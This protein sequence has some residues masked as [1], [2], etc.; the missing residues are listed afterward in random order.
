MVAPS[1]HSLQWEWLRLLAQVST[2][3]LGWLGSRQTHRLDSVRFHDLRHCQAS[4]LLA[5]GYNIK[6]ISELLGHRNASTTLNIYSH[7]MPNIQA[8]AAE[9]LERQLTRR[10]EASP[11][12]VS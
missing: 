7:L 1:R 2:S 6:V 9:G 5:D 10:E 3:R 4:L 12:E 8:A 11:S